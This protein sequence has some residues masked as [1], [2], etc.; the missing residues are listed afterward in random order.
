[1]KVW[2]KV[3]VADGIDHYVTAEEDFKCSVNIEAWEYY[4]EECDIDHENWKK[5]NEN[6]EVVAVVF[7]IVKEDKGEIRVQY[8]EDDYDAHK[9]NLL[10]QKAVKEAMELMKEELDNYFSTN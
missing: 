8:E 3:E 9:S 2:T 7:A 1:M 5:Y 4:D 10:I 6:W